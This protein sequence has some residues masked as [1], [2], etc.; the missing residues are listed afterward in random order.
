MRENK[1]QK[2]SKYGHISRS[3]NIYL[4]LI[5]NGTCIFYPSEFLKDNPQR[6]SQEVN[7]SRWKTR[8]FKIIPN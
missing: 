3:V 6:S 8:K 4:T 7:L 1:D 2:S 5:P